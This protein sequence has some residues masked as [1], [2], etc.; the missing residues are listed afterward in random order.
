M[1]KAKRAVAEEIALVRQRMWEEIQV[2]HLKIAMHLDD[3]VISCLPPFK[4]AF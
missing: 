3:H 4:H 2:Q 1:Q